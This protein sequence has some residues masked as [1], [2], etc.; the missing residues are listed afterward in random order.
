MRARRGLR[1][2]SISRAR[3]PSLFA[4]RPSLSSA[5]PG[6]RERSLLRRPWRARQRS[7]SNLPVPHAG[8]GGGDNVQGE[9]RCG[10]SLLFPSPTALSW[11]LEPRSPRGILKPSASSP[12][13]LSPHSNAN[14]A[15]FGKDM[16]GGGSSP[17]PRRLERV[18]LAAVFARSSQAYTISR[19]CLSWLNLPSNERAGA[20]A[21]AW[22][23]DLRPSLSARRRR[24]QPG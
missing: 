12:V 11:R 13:T 18:R 9:R 2:R 23:A 17:R 3:H 15:M 6:R 24:M 5:R 20:F 7:P 19:L 22:S 21:R 8:A 16:A 1:A 14:Q 4:A 10:A